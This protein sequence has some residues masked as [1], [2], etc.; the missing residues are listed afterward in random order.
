MS[1]FCKFCRM[2]HSSASCFHPGK[3]RIAEL[4]AANKSLCLSAGELEA[5]K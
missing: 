4:E 2:E 5:G 3:A 1:H